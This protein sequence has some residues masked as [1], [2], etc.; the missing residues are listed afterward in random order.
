MQWVESVKEINI[1]KLQKR[2]YLL[3]FEVVKKCFPE[4]VEFGLTLMNK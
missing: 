2:E 4:E 3:P 1:V